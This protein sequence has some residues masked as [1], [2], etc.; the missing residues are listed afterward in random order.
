M[1]AA[2]LVDTP[3]V[4]MPLNTKPGQG[5]KLLQESGINNGVL[6]TLDDQVMQGEHSHPITNNTKLGQGQQLLQEALA[7]AGLVDSSD[8]DMSLNTTSTTNIMPNLPIHPVSD[9][10]RNKLNDARTSFSSGISNVCSQYVQSGHVSSFHVSPPHVDQ[11]EQDNCCLPPDLTCLTT[12][13]WSACPLP[14]PAP[15]KH[16][17]DPPPRTPTVLNGIT[18]Y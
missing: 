15:S 6:Q 16:R 12:R 14:L 13:S 1:A 10:T 8:I 11:V 4:D 9:M 5:Q 18:V 17:A 7:T 2:G 3:D